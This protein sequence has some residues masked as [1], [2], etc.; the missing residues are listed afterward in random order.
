MGIAADMIHGIDWEDL[1]QK[2]LLDASW[3]KRE[4]DPV[5]FFDK[6]AQWYNRTVMKRTDDIEKMLSRVA[7]DH[8]CSILDIGSGPG[9]LAIPLAKTA[10]KVTAVDPSG[11]MLGLLGE[12]ARNAGLANI[13]AINKKWEDVV[14]GKDIDPHEIVIASHSL[15]M[16]DIKAALSKMDKA[17]TQRVYIF[18]FSGKPGWDYLDLWP[19]LY[20]EAYIPGPDYIFVVNI[21]YQMGIAANVEIFEHQGQ[22]QVQ[23]LED[24]VRDWVEYFDAPL[25]GAE[26]IIREYLEKNLVKDG[27]RVITQRRSKTAMIWWEAARGGRE[28]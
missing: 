7:V 14:I 9:P 3:R 27:N 15:A 24:A 21:L 8:G 20:G 18:I 17:A 12:N 19:K 2:S 28:K 25:P 26:T 4:Q 6:K 22:Q 5:R 1:W 16:A 11:K 10:G 23:D 13:T